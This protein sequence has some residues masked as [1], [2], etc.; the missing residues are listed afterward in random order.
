MMG[1][2]EKVKGQSRESLLKE[3]AEKSSP[4]KASPD[5]AKSLESRV[6]KIIAALDG[7]GRWVTR[8]Y[9]R[10]RNWEFNDRVETEVFV[11]NA[12]TLAA[13]LETVKP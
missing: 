7:N 6:R 12:E 5:D 1:Y 11:R 2:Y 3:K 9:I 8:G 10:H 4:R 13:Y